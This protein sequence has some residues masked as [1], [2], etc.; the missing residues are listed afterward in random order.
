MFIGNSPMGLAMSHRLRD[1]DD[2]RAAQ[3][4]ENLPSSTIAARCGLR[5]AIESLNRIIRIRA[6][7]AGGFD[8]S[9]CAPDHSVAFLHGFAALTPNLPEGDLRW[10]DSSL[11]VLDSRIQ[12]TKRA[13]DGGSD[14]HHRKD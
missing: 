13:L 14:C 1:T 2:V 7:A 4:T 6:D 11:Y 9:A 8:D 3:V 12:S 10:A 5:K